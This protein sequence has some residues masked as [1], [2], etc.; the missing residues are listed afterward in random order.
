MQ[1]N[2]KIKLI[3][4]TA[5]NVIL[6]CLVIFFVGS[7]AI[8][9][10]KNITANIGN[11]VDRLDDVENHINLASAELS[12]TINTLNSGDAISS[13]L[14]IKAHKFVMLQLLREISLNVQK[15]YDSSD[16]INTLSQYVDRD[17]KPIIYDLK[18]S[19][20]SNIPA[21]SV[22]ITTITGLI[23]NQ[24]HDSEVSREKSA[25]P[26]GNIIQITDIQDRE[27]KH[28]LILA[29]DSI[30]SNNIDQA[31]R[32]LTPI[33]D[34]YNSLKSI[35]PSMQLKNSINTLLHQ[36]NELVMTSA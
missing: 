13:D 33:S 30:K 10:V 2:S 15:G 6:C 36:L 29:L 25:R 35:I 7:K 19:Y 28:S 8:S 5:I 24:N 21:N 3:S 17:T 14:K 32:Y 9:I 26:L 22:F 1:K 4:Y 31:L 20:N 27:Y 16:T 18:Q 11:I 34:K 23:E 12:K